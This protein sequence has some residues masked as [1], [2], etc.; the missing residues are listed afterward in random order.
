MTPQ[1]PSPAA[2][3][4]TDQQRG[5]DAPVPSRWLGLAHA[6]WVVAALLALGVFAA[7]IPSA[8]RFGGDPFA[9]RVIDA[10]TGLVHA[11]FLGASVILFATAPACLGLAGLLV[12][13]K[14][15]DLMVLF[16]SFYLLLYGTIWTGPLDNL[17]HLIS[18][19]DILRADIFHDRLNAV[20]PLAF[21]WATL[22]LLTLFPTGRFV[23][24]WTRWL[25]LLA[26]LTAPLLVAITYQWFQ[27]LPTLWL[28]WPIALYTSLTF[29]AAGYAQVYRYR[30]VSSPT[31]RQQTKWAVSGLVV[32]VLLIQVEFVL[33]NILLSWPPSAALPWWTLV[34]GLLHTLEVNVVPLTLAVAVLRYRVFD[35]DILIRRTLVYATLTVILAAVYVALVLGGQAVVQAVTGQTG[36]QPVFIVISTLLVAALFTPLR[37]RLQAVI[38]RRFYRRKYN[39]AR[40]LEAF[41]ATLRIETDLEQLSAQLVAVVRETMQPA[42]VS[43]WLRPPSDGSPGGPSRPSEPGVAGTKWSAGA[44][45][46]EPA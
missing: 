38:D 11:V 34:F 41:G 24:S 26:T 22:A 3:T 30:H 25:V 36:Q 29:A 35:I 44:D 27:R 8:L 7:S 23:P 20:H 40:T 42:H 37:R 28:L 9:G 32:A 1:R 18:R 15:G 21:W 13:R 4:R 12:W 14:P 10:P 39:A 16:V 33:F 19:V 46:A 6:G 2:A 17:Y 45:S 5:A 31:E 43:L